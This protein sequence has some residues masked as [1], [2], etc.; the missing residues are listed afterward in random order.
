MTRRDHRVAR[1]VPPGDRWAFL[2]H[3]TMA[4]VIADEQRRRE[5]FRS[6]EGGFSDD[7]ITLGLTVRAI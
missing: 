1:D 5:F 3:R 6:F 7:E 2:E 4:E